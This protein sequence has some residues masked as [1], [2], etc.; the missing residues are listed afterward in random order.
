MTGKS[1]TTIKLPDGI[2]MQDIAG[3]SDE[4]AKFL[5]DSFDANICMR[6]DSF[7]IEGDALEVDF[8]KKVIRELIRHAEAGEIINPDVMRRILKE[9][10][11]PEFTPAALRNGIVHSY[12]GNS[13]RPKTV[14]QRRYV[15]AIREN[16][17]TFGL[18]P[19]GT[20]KT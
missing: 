16:T 19:A 10:Q 11:L 12:K 15:D 2:T 18:G 4:T 13:I 5:Q 8:I 17:I 14:G 1:S 3:I 6:G 9:L 20:G 7:L